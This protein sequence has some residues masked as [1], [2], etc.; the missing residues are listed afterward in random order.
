MGKL[1]PMILHELK[2][3]VRSIKMDNLRLQALVKIEHSRFASHIEDFSLALKYLLHRKKDCEV[4]YVIHI[5]ES[6]KSLSS[7]LTEA[8]TNPSSIESAKEELLKLQRKIVG[9]NLN[10]F[11]MTQ[12]FSKDSF[13]EQ[14]G[15]DG[16]LYL[17]QEILRKRE[18]SVKPGEKALRRLKEAFSHDVFEDKMQTL[19]DI[20]ELIF[21]MVNK[22]PLKHEEALEFTMDQNES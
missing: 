1:D 4:E 18:E 9:L 17:N 3:C 12:G 21:L 2:D 16:Y 15:V 10:N 11:S 5:N 22:P 14:L 20:E 6:I 8:P 13:N 7:L 19:K